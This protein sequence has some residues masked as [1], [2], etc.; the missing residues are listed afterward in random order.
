MVACSNASSSPFARVRPARRARTPASSRRW[1]S[2]RGASPSQS[3]AASLAGSPTA[4]TAFRAMPASVSAGAH[5]AL[6]HE[7]RVVVVVHLAVAPPGPH[8]QAAQDAGDRREREAVA[9][10][11]D[12]RGR[13]PLPVPVSAPITRVPAAAASSASSTAGPPPICSTTVVV[14]GSPSPATSAAP[15]PPSSS[16]RSRVTN[17]TWST[18]ASCGAQRGAARLHRH[19][20]RVLVAARDARGGAPPRREVGT[21]RGDAHRAAPRVAS[22]SFNVRRRTLPDAVRGMAS[23]NT[24]SSTCLYPRELLRDVRR[25]GRR[26]WRR[27]AR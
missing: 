4:A 9:V 26:R 3:A 13:G 25:A 5:A 2:T 19:G 15:L 10:G 12:H 11:D 1:S 17:T 6:A 27:R 14:A 18:P 7:P 20:E 21:D 23:T 24:T 22:V 8:R 16:G